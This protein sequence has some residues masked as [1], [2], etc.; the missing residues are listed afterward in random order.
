MIL[1]SFTFTGLVKFGL[2][3][4]IPTLARQITQLCE[5]G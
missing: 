2:K 1:N 5:M 4:Q 3:I